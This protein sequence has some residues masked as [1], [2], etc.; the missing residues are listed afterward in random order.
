MPAAV[1]ANSRGK[2]CDGGGVEVAQIVCELV[3]GDRSARRG[4]S[5]VILSLRSDVDRHRLVELLAV[6]VEDPVGERV[7]AAPTRGKNPILS[8]KPSQ[9]SCTLEPSLRCSFGDIPAGAT[10]TVIARVLARDPGVVSDTAA[11]T[12]SGPDPATGDDHSTATVR[13]LAAP[14]TITK[15]A[16]PSHVE[17]GSTVSF[18]VRVTNQSGTRVRDVSVCDRSPTGLVHVSGGTL[19]GTEVC[20]KVGSL[21]ARHSRRFVVRARATASHTTVV[22]NLATVGAPRRSHPKR[23]RH[24]RDHQ[25]DAYLHRV[26]RRREDTRSGSSGGQRRMP[27]TSASQLPAAIRSWSPRS[28][29]VP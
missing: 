7:D 4:A 2:W 6:C 11:V 20:W 8:L 15:R 25:P 12:A 23:T 24:R 28:R 16:S 14:L 13:I 3:D 22:T 17:S 29:P 10:V 9:G 5:A 18:A 27:A 26:R 19:H 21:A 1:P